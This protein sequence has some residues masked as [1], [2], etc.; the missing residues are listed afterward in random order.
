MLWKNHLCS[1]HYKLLASDMVIASW[2]TL[3]WIERW[4]SFSKLLY[5]PSNYMHLIVTYLDYWYLKY[6][7]MVKKTRKIFFSFVCRKMFEY[8]SFCDADDV[9][10]KMSDIWRGSYNL[11]LSKCMFV[12]SLRAIFQRKFSML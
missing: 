6:F 3:R 7:R 9:I 4:I 8:N 5:P 11:P 10:R 2:I 1:K 12:F